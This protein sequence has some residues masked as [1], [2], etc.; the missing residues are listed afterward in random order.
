MKSACLIPYC[1]IPCNT[2]ARAIYNKH[3]HFLASLGSCSIL[4]A[5]SRPVGYGWTSEAK[6]ILLEQGFDLSF[7]R[8][9]LWGRFLQLYGISYALFFKMLHQEK[10]FGHSNPYH[11]YA[12]HSDWLYAVTKGYDIC[13]IHYSYWARLQTACPKVVVVHDLW[14]DIMWEGPKKETIELNSSDLLVTVSYDDMLK[15]QGRGLNKVHWSPP[16]IEESYLEDSRE[17]CIVGSGNRHNVEGL[18]WLQNNLRKRVPSKI[19]VYGAVADSIVDDDRFV[20]HGPYAN[21]VDPYRHCGIVLMLTKEGTGLQIKGIEA[22][23]AG[24]AVVARKGA[25]RGLPRDEIGWIETESAKELVQIANSLKRDDK[26]RRKLIERGRAYYHRHLK[27][28]HVIKGLH[29]HYLSLVG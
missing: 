5:K 9:S 6:E 20:R 16:C 28:E 13:E 24:R 7:A 11:R 26:C 4:S 17:I 12:F 8:Q 19:H 14:S 18:R 10:A 21:P 23:A 15:L 25:M 2:G 29:K 3:L 22:L 1:P 27:N